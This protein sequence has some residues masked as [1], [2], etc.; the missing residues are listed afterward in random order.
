MPTG[1]PET[2]L[3]V[4]EGLLERR[5]LSVAHGKDKDTNSR[6][7]GGKNILFYS[8]VVVLFFELF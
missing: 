2:Y 7:L 5:R 1:D 3:E 8:V 4:W 6:D